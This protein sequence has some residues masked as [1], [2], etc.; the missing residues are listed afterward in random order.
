MTNDGVSS[1]SVEIRQ[2]HTNMSLVKSGSVTCS[3][4]SRTGRIATRGSSGVS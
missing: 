2:R 4:S 1:H 3:F